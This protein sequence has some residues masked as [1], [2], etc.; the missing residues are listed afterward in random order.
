[1]PI[2]YQVFNDL[3]T[4]SEQLAHER[5]D[6]GITRD[7]LQTH[8]MDLLVGGAYSA[9]ELYD[10]APPDLK[11]FLKGFVP[12]LKD[13]SK[14]SLI[15]RLNNPGVIVSVQNGTKYFGLRR[16]TPKGV[17]YDDLT[18]MLTDEQNEER[19]PEVRR[20]IVSVW[21]IIEYLVCDWHYL[22][23]LIYIYKF[24]LLDKIRERNC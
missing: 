6:E 2:T 14:V 13:E 16:K 7:E 10:L 18:Q 12:R 11:K 19:I 21:E 24:F 3:P 1:M 8:W 23:A 5:I 4:E 17:S 22:H 15:L 20:A 9:Q